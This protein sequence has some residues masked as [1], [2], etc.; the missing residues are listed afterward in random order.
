MKI[1]KLLIDKKPLHHYPVK[2][3]CRYYIG[4]R[5]RLPLDSLYVDIMSVM[6]ISY[7]N[8]IVA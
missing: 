5:I 8:H 3:M 7:S 1:G 4:I 2:I 6:N